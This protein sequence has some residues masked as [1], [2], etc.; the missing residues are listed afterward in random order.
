MKV[1]EDFINF[2]ASDPTALAKKKDYSKLLWIC[3][4]TKYHVAIYALSSWSR[5][6][7]LVPLNYNS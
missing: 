4:K 6:L 1:E 3:D 2:K 5:Y 7:N